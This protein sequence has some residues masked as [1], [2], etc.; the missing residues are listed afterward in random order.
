MNTSNS[1]LYYKV[2]IISWKRCDSSGLQQIVQNNIY[3]LPES[4][5]L[6]RRPQFAADLTK[7]S[8]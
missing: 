4:V 1:G 2:I 6:D 3:R 8:N 7:K 5:I